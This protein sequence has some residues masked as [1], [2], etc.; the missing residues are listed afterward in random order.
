[1]TLTRDHAKS[2]RL[3]ALA[4]TGATRSAGAPDLPTVAEAGVPGYEVGAYYGVIAP[5]G[6]PR[7]IVNRL[8]EE[9]ARIMRAPDVRELL[10][11]QGIEPVGSTPEEFARYLRTEIEKWSKIVKASDLRAE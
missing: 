3:R 6:T 7:A 1:M 11:V 9:L 10:R 4:T 8:S 2:G 5:V